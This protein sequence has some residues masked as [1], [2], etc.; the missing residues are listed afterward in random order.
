MLQG[1]AFL[2]A[3]KGWPHPILELLPPDCPYCV[4]VG[5]V[6]GA[7]GLPLETALVG[8]LQAFASNFIQAGIRLGVTGQTGAVE[9]LAG[10]EPVLVAT[11]ARASTS[12]LDDL[13]SAA[14]L[15][16]IAAMRH[17][18]QATRLFRS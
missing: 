4:A 5:A 17:E 3:A 14:L 8:Y 16:D 11:A 18:T 10:L 15:S 7:H 9:T 12:S 1:S 6:A 2:S 13:G